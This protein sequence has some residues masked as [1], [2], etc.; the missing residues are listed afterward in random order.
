MQADFDVGRARY[1]DFKTKPQKV[2]RRS[3]NNKIRVGATLALLME[4]D[5]NPVLRR[6]APGGGAMSHTTLSP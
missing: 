3:A 5:K 4:Q 6:N 2:C 1:S